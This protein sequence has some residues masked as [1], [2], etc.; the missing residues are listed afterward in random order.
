MEIQFETRK[1][2][3][4]PFDRNFY[5]L[6]LSHY[7]SLAE[8]LGASKVLRYVRN[9]ILEYKDDQRV[10]D[11]ARLL[12]R[13]LDPSILTEDLTD[14]GAE[15]ECG[16]LL[17]GQEYEECPVCEKK[18]YTGKICYYKQDNFCT[19]DGMDC[20]WNSQEECGKTGE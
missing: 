7:T 19:I 2:L 15:C 3:R 17:L 18:F 5:N 9:L 11:K 12:V 14:D 10:A 16:F 1:H 20:H 6:P 13:K 8:E 4:I